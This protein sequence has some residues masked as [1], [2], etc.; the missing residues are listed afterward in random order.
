[1]GSASLISGR[2]LNSRRGLRASESCTSMGRVAKFDLSGCPDGDSQ[3]G[4]SPSSPR[5]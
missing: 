3:E 4:T 5:S 1:M 2:V